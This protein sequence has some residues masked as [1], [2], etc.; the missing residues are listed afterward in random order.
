[1]KRRFTIAWIL[2]LLSPV[3]TSAHEGETRVALEPEVIS[4]ISAGEVEFRFQL[5]DTKVSQL[6]GDSDVDVS[7][8]KKLHML[9]YDSSLQEFQHVH[10]EFDGD[11]WKVNLSFLKSGDYW[12]WA[13]GT[14]ASDKYEFSSSTRLTIVNGEPAWPTPPVLTDVRRGS[15][16]NSVVSLSNQRLVAGRMVMLDI[17]F[18]R[19]DGSQQMITPYLG[20]FAHIVAVPED[21]DSLLHVHPMSGAQPNQGMV[22]VTFP[23][24]GFYRLWIQFI[25]EG[26]LKIVPLSVRVF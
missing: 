8:E 15:L 10:P 16:G 11:F 7:H 26:T 22:H 3:L 9:V 13:Q 14:L 1:M 23:S 21:G 12:I 19:N 5:V 2:F 25:D 24:A 18:T 6:V 4:P 17:N 20:A